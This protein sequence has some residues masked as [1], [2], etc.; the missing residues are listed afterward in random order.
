MKTA[1]A[2]GAQVIDPTS[3]ACPGTVCPVVVGNLLV[4][5]DNSHLSTAYVDWLAPLLAAQLPLR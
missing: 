5:R 2:A 3:W 1:A 4:Y